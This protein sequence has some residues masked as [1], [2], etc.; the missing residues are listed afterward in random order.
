MHEPRR[1]LD[2]GAD[3]LHA[4]RAILPSLAPLLQPTGLAVLELGRGQQA[5]VAALAAGVG[6]VEVACRDDLGGIPRALVL[7]R[8]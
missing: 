2:G 3:G 4:Y 7:K 1:A 8:Q 5:D 6:L